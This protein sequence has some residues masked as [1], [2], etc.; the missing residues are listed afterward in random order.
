VYHWY[1]YSS[2]FCYTKDT[3]RGIRPGRFLKSDDLKFAK[4]HARERH[5]EATPK[6]NHAIFESYLLAGLVANEGSRNL[7]S[8]GLLE[9]FYLQHQPPSVFYARERVSM[10][11]LE[12]F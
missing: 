9:A 11:V 6:N 3:A 8:N 4:L 12:R 2:G 5:I 10:K 7:G 1:G